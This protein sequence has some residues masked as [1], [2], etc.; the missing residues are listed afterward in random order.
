MDCLYLFYSDSLSGIYKEHPFNPIVVDPTCARMGGRIQM[1]K[2]D[3]YR[4]GQNNSYGYGEKISVMKI[5]QLGKN[6]YSEERVSSI[7][8]DSVLGPHTIDIKNNDILFDFYSEDF[9]ILAG[10]RRIIGRINKSSK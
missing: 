5:K 10:Y 9:N 8:I 1:I 7:N 2:G 3:L 4:F 6:F